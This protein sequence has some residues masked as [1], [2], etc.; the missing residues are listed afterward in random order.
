MQLSFDLETNHKEIEI[1]RTHISQLEHWKTQVVIACTITAAIEIFV[2]VIIVLYWKQIRW[3]LRKL[4]CP[5]VSHCC[6][7]PEDVCGI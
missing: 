2:V 5:C 1:T 4:Q 6:F 7:K 3:S